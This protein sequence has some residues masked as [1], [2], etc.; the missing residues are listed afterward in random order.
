[1][2][3]GILCTIDFSDT[4][5][6]VLRWSIDLAQK[7]NEHLTVLHTYRLLNRS[8]GALEMKKKFESDALKNFSALEKDL[9]LNKGVPYEFKSEVGFV[10]DR[11]KDHTD[12]NEVDF[13]VIGKNNTVDTNESLNDL[14]KKVDVPLIIVP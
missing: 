9:L 11:V 3:K 14:I 1:M 12:R 13:L 6:E 10:A 4:S 2:S 8:G 5:R 7:L